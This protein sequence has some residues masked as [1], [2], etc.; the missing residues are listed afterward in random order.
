MHYSELQLEEMRQQLAELRI[1]HRDLDHA[2]ELIQQGGYIDQLQ[3]RRMKKRKL[4][5]KD[6]ITYIGNA[7]IPD[8]PA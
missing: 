1:E 2:L 6:M 4:M 8:E 5:L 3:I 7:L